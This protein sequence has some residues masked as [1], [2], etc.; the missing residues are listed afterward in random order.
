MFFFHTFCQW[1]AGTRKDQEQMHK[2]SRNPVVVKSHFPP[3]CHIWGFSQTA[4][5][6]YLFH[7]P[8]HTVAKVFTACLFDWRCEKHCD[9][10]TE[11]CKN[12]FYTLSRL[13]QIGNFTLYCVDCDIQR[14]KIPWFGSLNCAESYVFCCPKVLLLCFFS[15]QA[16]G[17]CRLWGYSCACCHLKEVSSRVAGTCHDIWPVWTHHPATL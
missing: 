10:L 15:R 9:L 5:L 7:W 14:K 3:K 11:T 4:T 16:S 6:Y 2:N 13:A 17:L 12:I 1:V 8:K